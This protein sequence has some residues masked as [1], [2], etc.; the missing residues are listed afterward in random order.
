MKRNSKKTIVTNIIVFIMTFSLIGCG[1]TASP[2]VGEDV[3]V[4]SNEESMAVSSIEG[5]KEN[6]GD[7]VTTTEATESE[8]IDSKVAGGDKSAETSSPTA[9]PTPTAKPTPT[10]TPE[11][12]SA[13]PEPTPT[14]HVHE[15]AENI[16][17]QPTCAM[18]GEKKLTCSCGDTK[19]ESIPAS[20]EH[21]WVEQTQIVH[22]DEVGSIKTVQVGTNTRTV[23]Y[24][25]YCRVTLGLGDDAFSADNQTDVRNHCLE[26]G[27][28]ILDAGGTLDEAREHATARGFC[29]DYSDPV[30]EEQYIV[31]SPAYDET[32]VTSY[33]CS[34]CG[35]TK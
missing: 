34:V 12:T 18:A 7:N 29:I 17:V 24:C 4:E 16:T 31:Q 30:Y 15:Y 3:V 1:N 13:T 2:A 22:H 9:T 5:I 35:A 6:S 25:L 26:A 10:S 19:T 21:N 11:P 8:I 28:A 33:I 23:Y 32:V 20:G 27:Q 14:L